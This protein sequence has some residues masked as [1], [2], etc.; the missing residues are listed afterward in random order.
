M[1]GKLDP[2]TLAEVHALAVESPWSRNAF[3][4]LL[5]SPGVFALGDSL[6]VILCRV[7]LD[8][9]EILTLAV[10]PAARRAGLGRN[11]VQAAA[12]AAKGLGAD[13]LF[14]EVAEDN[15][16]ARALYAGFG[17][18]PSGQR[19]R[20]YA[21]PNGDP[22]DALLFTLNLSRRLSSG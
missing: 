22:V 10:V 14:L 6:G 7:V 3:S 18:E 9:A 13:R 19:R 21:R 5:G 15:A 8:E 11:L 1:A 4:D 12:M 17:F 2:Q 16:A 20:Y